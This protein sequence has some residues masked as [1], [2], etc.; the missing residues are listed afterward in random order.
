M[1]S[2]Q[3]DDAPPPAGHYSQAIVHNGF[4][5]VAGQLPIAPDGTVLNRASVGDQ[6]RTVLRNIDAILKAAGSGLDRAVQ[7]TIYVTD[8]DHWAEVN[9]AYVEVLGDHK[10][11]RAVIPVRELHHG[12]VLE[13]QTIAAV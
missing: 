7:I 1:K 13:V 2:I 11:A 6:T 3:T 8:I 10:P 9:E 12:V 5:F 4:A